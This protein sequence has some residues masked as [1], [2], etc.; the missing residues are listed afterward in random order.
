MYFE[1]PAEKFDR[2]APA[3]TLV[4]GSM[5]LATLFFL[6]VLSPI[7]SIAQQAAQALVG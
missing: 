7:M 6:L 5:G 1:A 2:Y 4:S 3:L